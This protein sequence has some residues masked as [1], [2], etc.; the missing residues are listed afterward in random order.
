LKSW[1]LNR[2]LTKAA[3]RSSI[4]KT[5]IGMGHY[6]YE[7]LRYRNLGAIYEELVEETAKEGGKELDAVGN[8]KEQDGVEEDLSMVK[9]ITSGRKSGFPHIAKVRFVISEGAYLVM[10]AGLRSDWFRNAL[11]SKS[12]SVRDGHSL[13]AVTCEEF[14]DEMEVKR[15]FAEK[16]GAAVLDAWYSGTEIRSLKLTPIGHNPSPNTGL[17][18]QVADE[19]PAMRGVDHDESEH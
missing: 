3:R 9:V 5:K 6:I 12:A 11:A 10:G 7:S 18:A 14:L 4:F 8:Q 1:A 13:L 17:R 15:L 2:R 19:L 16:Y